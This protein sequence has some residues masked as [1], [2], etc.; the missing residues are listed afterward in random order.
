[1]LASHSDAEYDVDIAAMGA[2]MLTRGFC[3]HYLSS[4]KLFFEL[5]VGAGYCFGRLAGHFSRLRGARPRLLRVLL[6]DNMH[7]FSL[8]NCRRVRRRPCGREESCS[9]LDRSCLGKST[10]NSMLYELLCSRR[11]KS[12]QASPSDQRLRS[13][14]KYTQSSLDFYNACLQSSFQYLSKFRHGLFSCVQNLR[15][16]FN[17]L[18]T[19]PNG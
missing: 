8:Q 5:A 7:C 17:S 1:M 4:K 16:T 18:L 2:E 3:D 6:S 15:Q 12:A 14:R 9:R 13:S 10:R 11:A 19:W